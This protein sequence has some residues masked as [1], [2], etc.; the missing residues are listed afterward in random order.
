MTLLGT[1][2]LLH[3]MTVLNLFSLF[4]R[5]IAFWKEFVWTTEAKFNF[6]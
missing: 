1:I 5:Y 2:T 6:R 3:T 4:V